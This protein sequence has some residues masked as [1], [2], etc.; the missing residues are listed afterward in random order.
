MINKHVRIVNNK[1]TLCGYPTEASRFKL[2]HLCGAGRY[3][4][5]IHVRPDR[6][7]VSYTGSIFSDGYTLPAPTHR[8]NGGDKLTTERSSQYCSD[9][10]QTLLK[11]HDMVCS[12]SRKG[13]CWDNIMMEHFYTASNLS[14]CIMLITKL[15][16][17]SGEV[18]SIIYRVFCNSCRGQD[19]P[20][21]FKI[22]ISI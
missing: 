10:F 7:P 3:A 2:H 11:R 6:Y 9:D 5:Q 19:T 12:M 13:N 17:K 21:P 18:S 8:K 14:R 16:V 20:I 1:R 4:H 22:E 15:R